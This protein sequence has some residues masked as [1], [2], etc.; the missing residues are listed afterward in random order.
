MTPAI[1]VRL[2]ELEPEIAADLQTALS[3][4]LVENVTENPQVVFCSVQP[5]S[6]RRALRRFPKR[7]VVVASRLPEVR[8][9]LDA[10]EAGASDYCAAPFESMQLNWILQNQL[11]ARHAAAA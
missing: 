8:A 5:Q 4:L 7:A 11:N 2:Y 6:L 10:L 1:R 9:W 3:S